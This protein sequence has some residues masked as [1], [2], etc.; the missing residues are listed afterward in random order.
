M[1]VKSISWPGP[2]AINAAKSDNIWFQKHPDRCRRIR[3]FIGG[4]AGRKICTLVERL[5]SG[6][7]ERRFV[8]LPSHTDLRELDTGQAIECLS[9]YLLVVD[10]LG[11][12][13]EF[14]PLIDLD[15]L[16]ARAGVRS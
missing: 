5:P 11:D 16:F 9:Q 4:E 2:G 15:H 6:I 3:P 7:L 10:I 14:A 1:T 12:P 8:T 13:N